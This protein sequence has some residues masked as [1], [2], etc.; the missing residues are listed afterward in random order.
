MQSFESLRMSLPTEA[1]IRMLTQIA[2]TGTMPILDSHGHPTP[3]ATPA[4]PQM[5]YDALKYLTD[6]TVP[7]AKATDAPSSSSLDEIARKSQVL[8]S[9]PLADLIKLRDEAA[10]KA[11]QVAA[12]QVRI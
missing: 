5:R 8:K 11:A 6:K 2:L 4:T 3:D 12:A 7:Q 10:A 1:F 9:L